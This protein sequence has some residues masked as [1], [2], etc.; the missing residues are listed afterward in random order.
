MPLSTDQHERYSRQL[1]LRGWGIEG[2]E[3]LLASRVFVAG[4]GGLGCAAA[5]YLAE[6]GVGEL[7]GI[8]LYDID[9]LQNIAADAKARRE[10]QIF[11]CDRL[12]VRQMERLGI[13]PL[14]TAGDLS[15][16]GNETGALPST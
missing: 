7:S 16:G 10:E 8:Y 1:D 14:P 5:V 2:Q 13:T 15:K 12:I 4:V 11:L 9:A 6:A 3:R